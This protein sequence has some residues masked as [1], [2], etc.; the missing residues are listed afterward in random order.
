MKSYVFRENF[1]YNPDPSQDQLLN[2]SYGFYE[3]YYGFNN[4][5]VITNTEYLPNNV[6]LL[7]T[8]TNSYTNP[9]HY[10]VTSSKTQFPDNSSHETNY[11][12]AHEKNNQKLI[13]ANMIG[14]PLETKTV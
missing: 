11:S 4:P 8:T 1:M 3:N 14:I 7:T 13:T 9:A 12:Y 5:T 10:Q 6:T 2:I